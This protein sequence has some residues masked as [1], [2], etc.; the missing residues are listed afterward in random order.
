VAPDIMTLAKGIASGMPLGLVVAKQKY[1][2]KW[3]PGA[4][5]N[6]YGGNPICCAAALATLELVE[7]ELMA[8]AA[9]VGGYLLEKLAALRQRHPDVIGDIRGRGLMIG[10][11]LVTDQQ[12]RAPARDLAASVLH[13][14]FRR[15]LLLL[16]CGL[17]TVRLMPPLIVTRAEVDEAVEILD[18]AIKAS[19]VGIP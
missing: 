13:T 15:G 8:N 4:H 3:K 9:A 7:T 17:S 2:S 11:E 12:T 6:T 10:I 16:T 14:A 19:A 1:M 5:G 18:A